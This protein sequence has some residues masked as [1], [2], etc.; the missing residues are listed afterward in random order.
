[1]LVT[2][3]TVF[4]FAVVAGQTIEE[5]ITKM[6]KDFGEALWRLNLEL[7]ETPM[8]SHN[9]WCIEVLRRFKE[10]GNV[11][12]FNA[13]CID[14]EQS[15]DLENGLEDMSNLFI[16][17]AYPYYK[18]QEAKRITQNT[19]KNYYSFVVNVFKNAGITKFNF[20]IIRL[21]EQQYSFYTLS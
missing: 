15:I 10:R 16:Q 17:S 18:Q 8:E 5:I 20:K 6:G 7:K 11:I 21:G 1:M 13:D 3:K 9:A 14:F 12:S 2:K 19:D 4:S